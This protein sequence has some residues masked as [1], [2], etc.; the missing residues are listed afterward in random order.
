MAVA[1]S[2]LIVTGD[3]FRPFRVG[4]RWESATWKNVRWLDGIAGTAA[5]V[6]GWDVSTVSWDPALRRSRG[7]IDIPAIFDALGLPVSRAGWIE[8]LGYPKLPEAIENDLR[9]MFDAD[10]VIGYEM[11]D[12][13][14]RI[15]DRAGTAVIDVILHPVRFLDDVMFALRTN[16]ADIHA[17]LTRHAVPRETMILQA[18]LIK[19]KAAWM[20]PPLPLRPG[21]TLV[22]GQVGDDRAAINVATGKCHTLADHADKLL[23]LCTQS[24]MVLFKPHPYDAEQS[25][26]AVTMR[27]LQCVQW[28]S[29]NFYHLIA[30]PEIDMVCALN[31]SGLVEAEVFGKDT[32]WL[33]PPLYRFGDKGPLDG[34]FGEAM[35]QDGFW[36]EPGFWSALRGS[37]AVSAALPPRPNRLRRALNADWG[38]SSIDKV[39]A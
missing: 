10:L 13:L 21:A 36:C 33:A 9:A 24:S 35:P 18:G 29:A 8:L 15:L 12:H 22:L 1:S 28:T 14:L 39:V 38:F 7:N 5:R 30:Q 31:S 20:K 17:L 16:R 2:K 27:R 3:I 37:A 25:Q 32:L 23:E 11:P 4:E 19:S 34:E 26:N 6:A